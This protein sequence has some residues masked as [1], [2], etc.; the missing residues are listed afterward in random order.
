MDRGA[1]VGGWRGGSYSP[2]GCKVGH[3][4]SN[5]GAIGTSH[6]YSTKY[7]GN[8]QTPGLGHPRLSQLTHAGDQLALHLAWV[9]WFFSAW[10]SPELLWLPSNMVAGFQDWACSVRTGFKLQAFWSRLSLLKVSSKRNGG[11]PVT[12]D[13][14]VKATTPTTTEVK[15]D[16]CL[17]YYPK[18]SAGFLLS[19]TYFL[20]HNWSSQGKPIST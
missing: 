3:N 17:P 10:A 12:E 19:G 20:S 8:R 14:I 1:W 18:N 5:L 4:W 15:T 2:R 16:P 13:L 9:T 7:N 11:K 6:L